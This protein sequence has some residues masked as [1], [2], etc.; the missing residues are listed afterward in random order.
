MVKIN[1]LK[2]KPTQVRKAIR[3]NFGSGKAQK[4]LLSISL[5]FFL[6]GAGLRIFVY[7]QQKNFSRVSSQYVEAEKVKEKIRVFTQ[8]KD[9]LDSRVSLLSGYLKK[10]IIWSDKLNQMRN[11]IPQ[12]AWLTK[13]SYEKKIGKDA[14][15]SFY[16]SGGMMVKGN[17]SP[18]GI[19]SSFV[20]QLKADKEFSADFDNPILSDLRTGIK[21]NLEIMVFTIEMPLRQGKAASLNGINR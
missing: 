8:E 1:L 21:D 12:E 9:E 7:R 3:F 4:I 6:I 5:I 10:E 19:L 11:L 13:V 18:I 20:N 17:I 14:S 2:T 16:I 15:S